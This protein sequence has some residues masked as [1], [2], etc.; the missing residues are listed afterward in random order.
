MS[1]IESSSSSDPQKNSFLE[2]VMNFNKGDYY[3]AHEILERIWL[4]TQGPKKHLLQSFIQLS[5][6]LYLI[7]QD[8]L[9]G[10]VKVFL[11]AQKNL[12][13]VKDLDNLNPLL[14]IIINLKNEVDIILKRANQGLGDDFQPQIQV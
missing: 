9:A 2:A 7:K 6:T 8:R 14:E 13:L 11:R 3:L 4:D 5:V 10:A 12:D 1:E